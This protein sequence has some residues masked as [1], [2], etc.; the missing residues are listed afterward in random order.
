MPTSA[1]TPEIKAEIERLEC[2]DIMVGI[3]SFKNAATIGYVVRAAQAGLVQYFP[4]LRPVLVNADAGSPDGTQRVVV[5]TEPPGYV[6]QILLVHPKNR[7]ARVSL[8]YPEVDG[9]GGKGAALRT[10]FEMAAA[11]QA[12]ALVVVDSDLRS[13]VPEWIELLAGPILKGGYDFVAPLYARHKYDGT[14]TNT[15]TYPVTRALYGHRI[16][17]PIGGDFGVSGD[18]IRYYLKQDTWTPDVSRFGVDIWMTTTALV[19]GFAVCQTRLGAKIHDPKDP[20]AD[21]GPMFRQVVGTLLRMARDNAD[22]WLPIT[23]SHDVPAYGFERYVEPLPV[24]VN[25]LRLLSQFHAGSLTLAETWQHMLAPDNYRSVALLAEQAG[26]L[27]EAAARRLGLDPDGSA[28][29]RG[30]MPSTDELSDAVAEFHFPDDLWVRTFYDL[31]IAASFGDTPTEKLVAALVPIYFGR[32]GGLV[33]ESRRLSGEQAEERVE[34]QAH[35]FE[36]LKPYLVDRWQ[37][38]AKRAGPNRPEARPAKAARAEA[39]PAEVERAKSKPAAP[40]RPAARPASVEAGATRRTTARS[41][42]SRRSSAR[43]TRQ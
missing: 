37:A 5:D 31:M 21:L 33:I 29:S 23:G 19:G 14:I 35:E 16:R 24:E 22:R 39:K 18:L 1:L 8:T 43:G 42:T 41:T 13:I 26:T 11:L 32:V 30:G 2:A 9:I 3:P 12:E 36:L 20:G 28:T 40:K 4:D 17:Q 25:T 15:V 38:E 6:E 10:L 34:R 7:L 27:A